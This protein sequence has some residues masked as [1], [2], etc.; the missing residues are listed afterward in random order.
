M[1]IFYFIKSNYFVNDF[2]LSCAILM[3]AT[4]EVDKMK[5][6]KF[7]KALIIILILLWII[8]KPFRYLKY[9]N[10]SIGIVSVVLGLHYIFDLLYSL[11]EKNIYKVLGFLF[12]RILIISAIVFFIAQSFIYI[13]P[14]RDSKLIDEGQIDYVIVLGAGLRGDELSQ[15]LKNRLDRLLELEFDDDVK[16]IM[17]GGQGDDEWISEA[18]AMSNYLLENGV[19]ENQII[20]EEES[21][22][23]YENFN[24]S[25]RK[26]KVM[27]FEFDEN[28]N[29]AIVTND[30]HIFRSKYILD[31]LGYKSIGVAAKTPAIVKLDYFFREFF[32]LINTIVFEF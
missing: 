22:S 14:Y 21:T 20:L 19:E 30:F 17:S 3:A 31:K 18:R 16:L 12:S 26:L 25:L 5:I 24:L 27:D 29:F 13:T 9:T 7:K 11:R 6:K 2:K 23:T 32:A 8:S 10:I 4:L 1:A 28:T 15:T